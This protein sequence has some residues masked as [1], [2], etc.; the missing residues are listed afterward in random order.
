VYTS[1]SRSARKAE[2]QQD[3]NNV[4]MEVLDV[5]LGNF[6]N[7]RHLDL[8]V[9]I[10]DAISKTHSFHHLFGE[11]STKVTAFFQEEEHLARAA[12]DSES[13]LTD[14]VGY[15]IDTGLHSKLDVENDAS[16][17]VHIL[18]EALENGSALLIDTV[19]PLLQRA[20]FGEYQIAVNESETPP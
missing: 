9:L 1:I 10:H 6:E 15:E 3:G 20:S 4:F 17:K 2:F 11:I 19:E 7:P 5:L 18:E 8:A 14:S 13:L 12:R 16:L